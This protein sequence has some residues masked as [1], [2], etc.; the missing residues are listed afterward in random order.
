MFINVLDTP[1]MASLQPISGIDYGLFHRP[2]LA[3]PLPT[4]KKMNLLKGIPSNAN[5]VLERMKGS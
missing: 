1:F 4:K 2:Q 3:Q 5:K